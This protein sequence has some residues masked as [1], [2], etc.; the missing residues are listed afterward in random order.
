MLRLFQPLFS[1]QVAHKLLT[2]L[3]HFENNM[4]TQPALDAVQVLYDNTHHDKAFR[5]WFG[6]VDVW[7][8]GCMLHSGSGFVQD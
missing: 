8:N 5:M 2:L 7:G 3:S 1:V 4:S 6:W